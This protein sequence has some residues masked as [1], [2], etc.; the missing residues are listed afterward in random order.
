MSDEQTVQSTGEDTPK[1][2]YDFKSIT[3]AVALIHELKSDLTKLRATKNKL[4][5]EN[6]QLKTQ[7]TEFTTKEQTLSSELEQLKTI[8]AKFEEVERQRREELLN[9]LPESKRDNYKDLDITILAKITQDFVA[10]QN[11]NSPG[12]L[13]K[14]KI[15]ELD[16]VLRYEQLSTEQINDLSAKDPSKLAKL[17]NEYLVRTNRR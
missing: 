11:L 5:R 14:Q 17:Y 3:E 12:G 16:N 13:D 6:E 8:K 15:P 1:R 10:E 7:L 2:S 9:K 4:A